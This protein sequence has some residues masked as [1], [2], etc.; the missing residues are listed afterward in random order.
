[1]NYRNT[2]A[3]YSVSDTP[4]LLGVHVHR[5]PAAIRHGGPIIRIDRRQLFAEP[6]SMRC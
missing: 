4:E 2:P 6:S 1:M 5:L 3:T